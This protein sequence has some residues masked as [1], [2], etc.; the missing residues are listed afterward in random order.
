MDNS[1]SDGLIAV[2]NVIREIAKNEIRNSSFPTY[3]AAVVQNVNDD[4]TI[5]VFIPPNQSNTVTNLLN[6]TGE[7][8]ETGD[9]VE[10]AT[11][12][13]SLTNCWI[14]IKHG[15]TYPSLMI[16]D[17]QEEVKN[18]KQSTDELKRE[19]KQLKEK[20]EK[21]H[22]IGSTYITN[23][24]VN[25]KTI[26]GFGEWELYDKEFK[27][28][29]GKISEDIPSSITKSSYAST[30]DVW[31]TRAGHNLHI[32]Y[33]ITTKGSAFGDGNFNLLTLNL[34]KFGITRFNHT[35]YHIAMSDGGNG[36]AEC[37]L[38]TGGVICT[39]DVITKASNGTI[40]AGSLLCANTTSFITKDNMLD[41]ACDKFY[42]RRTS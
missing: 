36:I 12:N 5:N 35:L 7:R 4:G 20:V 3:I 17:L 8:L 13:G 42:W 16:T 24:N 23:I 32:E 30:A 37:R 40:P 41:E 29:V 26:L 11:K 25:P 15:T 22:S 27:L 33:H 18:L 1:N 34:E 21:I 38:T 19:N 6:K 2:K 28:Y 31:V 10:I 14:A 9:S 39:D